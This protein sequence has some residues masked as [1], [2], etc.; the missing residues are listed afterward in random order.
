MIQFNT[1]EELNDWI[2]S[3]ENPLELLEV[4]G[5]DGKDSMWGIGVAVT[6]MAF[7]GKLTD[8]ATGFLQGVANQLRA[9]LEH[10]YLIPEKFIDEG[11]NE[12]NREA[13]R[14]SYDE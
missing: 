8:T 2:L 7:S 9:N 6:A 1:K 12:A 10:Q 5:A 3:H 4:E 11:I 13:E 14:G